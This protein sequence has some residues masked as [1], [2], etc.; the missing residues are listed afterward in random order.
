MQISMDPWSWL[1]VAVAMP[2]AASAILCSV[3]LSDRAKGLRP[4]LPPRRDRRRKFPN[5]PAEND[6]LAEIENLPADEAVLAAWMYSGETRASARRWR[7]RRDL[8]RKCMP[9]LARNLD[10]LVREWDTRTDYMLA[11]PYRPGL[12]EY[13]HRGALYGVALSWEVPGR[14]A[15][16][17][18]ARVTDVRHLHSALADALDRLTRVHDYHKTLS[19]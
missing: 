1:L 5:S 10:R 13:D 6:R 18:R 16:Y 12:T 15:R 7:Q 4:G 3:W 14:D 2:L 8:V 9:V 17:H 11:R 19:L